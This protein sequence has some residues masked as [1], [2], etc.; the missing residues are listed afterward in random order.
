VNIKKIKGSE[1]KF[2]PMEDSTANEI[3]K[4]TY[5]SFLDLM[6]KFNP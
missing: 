5:D 1:N 4:S 3:D 2:K 6:K